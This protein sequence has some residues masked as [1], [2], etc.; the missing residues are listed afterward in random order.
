MSQG[1][2]SAVWGRQTEIRCGRRPPKPPPL[3]KVSLSQQRNSHHPQA[4]HARWYD[5]CEALRLSQG[6]AEQT[7]ARETISRDP[8]CYL[9]LVNVVLPHGSWGNYKR[10]PCVQNNS[11]VPAKMSCIR[12]HSLKK[13]TKMPLQRSCLSPL[14]LSWENKIPVWVS[15]SESIR[16]SAASPRGLVQARKCTVSQAAPDSRAGLVIADLTSDIPSWSYFSWLFSKHWYST[17]L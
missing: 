7:H 17:S 11:V 6:W 14:H 8:W 12:T 16:E 4:L 3:L 2:G 9:V 5:T 1:R 15:L 13:E 10:F